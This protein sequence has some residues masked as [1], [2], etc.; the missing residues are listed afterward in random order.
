MLLMLAELQHIAFL[1]HPAAQ[2]HAAQQ[3]RFVVA[4]DDAGAV[5]VEKAGGR[6][7]KSEQR[8]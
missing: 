7:R 2:T 4:I 1:D 3:H 6:G 8:A 5:G